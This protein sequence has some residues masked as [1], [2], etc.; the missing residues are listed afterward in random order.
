MQLDKSL[1]VKYAEYPACIVGGGYVVNDPR[2]HEA[3]ATDERG[4][5]GRHINRNEPVGLMGDVKVTRHHIPTCFAEGGDH[6]PA[7]ELELDGL[8]PAA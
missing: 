1:E 7:I 8:S 4:R 2:L 5:G 3:G 6:L